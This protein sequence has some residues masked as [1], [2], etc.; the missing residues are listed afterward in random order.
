M[1][2]NVQVSHLLSF[3]CSFQYNFSEG[4]PLGTI[5]SDNALGILPYRASSIF[6]EYRNPLKLDGERFEIEYMFVEE[7]FTLSTSSVKGND[8]NASC[9]DTTEQ[10]KS[11]I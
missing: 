10:M 1:S 4:R 11:I 3:L 7:N 5:C 6:I 8:G 2:R 9:F